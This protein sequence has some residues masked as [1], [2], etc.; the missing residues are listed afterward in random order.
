MAEQRE[1][2]HDPTEAIARIR[3]KTERGEQLSPEE[4]EFV[5]SE[6]ARISP[7]ARPEEESQNPQPQP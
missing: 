3:A 6:R 1:D 2:E 7:E 5:D 4:R